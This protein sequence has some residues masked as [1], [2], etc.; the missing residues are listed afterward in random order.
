MK[1]LLKRHYHFSNYQIAQLEFFFKTVFSELSKI[2]IMAFIFR[3]ELD[4]YFFTLLAMCLL[5]TSTGG[6]HC[7]T[8]AR[9]L[10][11]SSLYM[12]TVIKILPLILLPLAIMLLLLFPCVFI[13]YFIGPV[14]SDVHMPLSE[15]T[16]NKNRFK[17]ALYVTLYMIV[18]MVNPNNIYTTAIFWVIIIHTLQLIAAKIRKIII[19]REKDET[20]IY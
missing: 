18:I 9:C 13:N 12:I 3:H 1:E 2:L 8:Y 19:R 5:R 4:V 17:A 16:I 11:A 6:L 7:K 10:V 15:E 20:E 14:T